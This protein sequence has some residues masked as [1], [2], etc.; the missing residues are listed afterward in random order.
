MKPSEALRLHRDEVVA[1]VAAHRAANPRVFG[2][3]ARGEDKESSDLDLLVDPV[4]GMSL[5]ELGVLRMDLE[6]LLHVPV[7][8]VTPRG[9]RPR[10][11]LRVL[12][13]AVP[14]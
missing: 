13:E 12:S 4:P 6:Q 1:M 14:L 2:S 10:M 9:L 8:V 11:K 3:V 5:I 7:D